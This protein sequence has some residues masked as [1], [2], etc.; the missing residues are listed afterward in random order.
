MRRIP[1]NKIIEDIHRVY[2]SNNRISEALYNEERQSAGLTAIRRKFGSWGAALNE[3]GLRNSVTCPECRSDFDGIGN[4][5]SHHP[6]HRPGISEY[7]HEILTGLLM[8]DATIPNRKQTGNCRLTCVMITREF[9]EW[10][11]QQF[12]PIGCEVRFHRS[13]EDIARTTKETGFSPGAR[14][15]NYSDQYLWETRSHPGI[16]IYA[17]WYSSGNK[18]F[19]DDLKLT[20]IILKMWYCCDGSKDSY[21]NKPKIVIS[22]SNEYRRKQYLSSLFKDIGWSPNLVHSED[23]DGNISL[24]IRFDS[25]SSE[26]LWKYM[27]EAPLGFEYKWP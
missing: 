24:S 13:A 16:N 22:T 27:G 20:P 10:L 1:K 15:E 3:A 7:Q 8:G 5:W 14:P 17:S 9:L 18:R 23:K 21:E 11:R 2:D 6:S 12:G 4:H 25:S 19:P 26:E